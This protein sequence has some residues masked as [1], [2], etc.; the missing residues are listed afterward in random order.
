MILRD[1]TASK[2]Y[3][4]LIKMDN[5]KYHTPDGWDRYSAKLS[6]CVT[7]HHILNRPLNIQVIRCD[8]VIRAFIV[9]YEY[10]ETEPYMDF[11]TDCVR[12]RE[13]NRVILKR[14]FYYKVGLVTNNL[15]DLHSKY[16]GGN[17][18]GTYM[19]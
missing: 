6:D 10:I 9:E 5:L 14:E 18:N 12:I 19:C 1:S 2:I 8:N 7:L 13:N 15:A 3:N 17:T 16:I 4:R 11:S